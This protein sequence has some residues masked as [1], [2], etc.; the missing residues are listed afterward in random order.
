MDVLRCIRCQVLVTNRLRIA[1]RYLRGFFVID[2]PELQI[3]TV[4]AQN[5]HCAPEVAMMQVN[6]SANLRHC[7]KPE[8]M[9]QVA[10][11]FPAELFLLAIQNGPHVRFLTGSAHFLRGERGRVGCEAR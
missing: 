5:F 7:P 11:V 9:A 3:L 2:A 8:K 4:A 10:S 1:K 6:N